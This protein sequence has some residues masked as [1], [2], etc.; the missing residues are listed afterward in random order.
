MWSE[1]R[2]VA[3]GRSSLHRIPREEGGERSLAGFRYVCDFA[4][5]RPTGE[6]IPS[7]CESVKSLLACCQGR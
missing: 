1:T 6:F 2:V 5:L 4:R 3:I 7:E